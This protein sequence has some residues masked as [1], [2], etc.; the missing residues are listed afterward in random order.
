MKMRSALLPVCLLALLSLAPSAQAAFPGQNGPIVFEASRNQGI[1]REGVPLSSYLYIPDIYKVNADGQGL[2]P[3]TPQPGTDEDPAVSPDGTKI[4]FAS[5]RDFASF[6]DF[7]APRGQ[8]GF[9]IYVMNADGTDQRRLTAPLPTKDPQ[10]ASFNRG[11][12]WSPDGEKI[13]F[14]SNRT[15]TANGGENYDIYVMN[16]ADG[17]GVERV[18]G[19]DQQEY[20]PAFSPDGQ[21]IAFSRDLGGYSHIYTMKSDGSDDPQRLT[22]RTDGLMSAGDPDWSPDSQRITFSGNKKVSSTGGHNLQ[23][24]LINADGTA[25]RALTTGTDAPRGDKGLSTFSPDG[26]KIV[27]SNLYQPGGEGETAHS[28]S[29]MWVMDAPATDDGLGT[30][31]S[32]FSYP[33]TD[34]RYAD[35]GRASGLSKPQCS[36]DLDNDGDGKKDFGDDPGC[37]SLDDDAENPDPGQAP[38]EGVPLPPCKGPTGN[39]AGVTCKYRPGG[40]LELTGTAGDDTIVGTDED[41]VIVGGGGN[42]VIVAK[43]GNDYVA[44]EA[45]HD[46]VYG[47][48]GD[49]AVN[50][51]TGNDLLRGEIGNDL[52]VGSDGNDSISGDAGHDRVYSGAG[53]DTVN[54]GTGND[55]L[56]GQS[57]N[58][59]LVG[60]DGNDYITGDAGNDRLYG[61]PGVDRLYGGPGTNTVRQ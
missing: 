1:N 21:K 46:R 30:A 59:L 11:P 56:R 14:S 38:G 23:V 17:S 58:D 36:D 60:S 39:S 9:D 49:D 5:D 53:D 35:W 51:G 13:A 33:N 61:G 47:G 10:N 24:W 50:G 44:G 8:K 34:E 31:F 18:A 28:T 27:F 16:A 43:G 25:Q 42:D 2:S 41:D 40:G 55:L 3:L 52:V 29:D 45:G 22:E 12:T 19:G 4:A 48:T 26:K 15:P 20:H 54:G 32:Q 7:E 6:F 37:E 57:G